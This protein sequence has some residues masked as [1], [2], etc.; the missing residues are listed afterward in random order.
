VN[1][2]KNIGL[3]KALGRSSS[4]AGHGGK[5]NQNAASLARMGERSQIADIPLDK[6]YVSNPGRGTAEA[7]YMMPGGEQ[8]PKDVSP[9]CA[10]PSSDQDF[11]GLST[12]PKGSSINQSN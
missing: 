3:Q 11:H 1:C 2:A 5:M 10:T 6:G 7:G 12:I 4:R 8:A 9:E